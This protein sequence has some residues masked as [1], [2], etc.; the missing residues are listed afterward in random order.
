MNVIGKPVDK[1][2]PIPYK[3]QNPI[4]KA[5]PTL[6]EQNTNLEMFETGIKVVNLI[7]PYLRS[8]KIGLFGDADVNKTVIIQ[9]LINNITTK[10]GN[11][12]MFTKIDKRTRESNNLWL[13][14][15]K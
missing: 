13:K 9:K 2:N 14:M 5:A 15:K 8:R 4:H 1:M 11:I 12:S 7:E 3:R 10:H 6:V